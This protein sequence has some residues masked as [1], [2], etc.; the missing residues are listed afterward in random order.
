VTT[1]FRPINGFF[2]SMVLSFFMTAWITYIN[3]GLIDGFW[4]L[5]MKAWG[6]AWPAAFVIAFVSGPHVMK[7]AK[8][9]S[10]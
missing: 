6:L 5:W 8:K 4:G 9:L 2:M 1:K 7:L 3:L 10:D